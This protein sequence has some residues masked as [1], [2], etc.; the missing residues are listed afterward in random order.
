LLRGDGIG[1]FGSA[2]A[3]IRSS[4][5][6]FGIIVEGARAV[7]QNVTI[8]AT[9]DGADAGVYL[10][11]YPNCGERIGGVHYG[12]GILVRGSDTTIM[13]V[14][15]SGGVSGISAERVRGLKLIN[16]RLDNSSGWGSYNH[17]VDESYFVGNSWSN[18]NRSCTAP[19]GI[20]LPTGCESAGWVCIACHKNIIASNTCTNSGDCYYINGEGNLQSNNNRFHRNECRASPH[21]CFEVTF[22]LGN[23]FVEN[24]ARADPD[25]GVGC[26]YPFWVGGSSV[27]FARNKWSCTIGPETALRHATDSTSVPTSIEHRK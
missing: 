26:K 6:G 19:D 16:N 20:Y 17:L 12:G 23:E 18:D 8:R 7:I 3:I 22:S 24:I 9:A 5:R 4:G 27:I 11:L 13:G 21:N 25:S 1:V 14:D 15:I 10:C 2:G